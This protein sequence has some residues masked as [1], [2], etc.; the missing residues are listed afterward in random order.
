MDFEKLALSLGLPKDS[1]KE[2]VLEAAAK[3]L[4]DSAKETKSATDSLSALS[5]QLSTHGLTVKDG[6]VEKLSTTEPKPEDSP[7]VADLKKRIAEEEKHT[8]TQILA[9]A[10]SEADRLVKEMKFP[11]SV[12][13]EIQQLLSIKGLAQGVALSKDGNTLEKSSVNLN[14]ILQKVL[15]SATSFKTEG[16][17]RYTPPTDDEKKKREELSAKGKSVARRVSGRKEEPATK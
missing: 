16:L 10:K 6:K 9:Y 11:A 3:R 4:L 14:P 1:P 5:Q 12:H 13:G 8:G 15:D 2:K 17:T 7:E